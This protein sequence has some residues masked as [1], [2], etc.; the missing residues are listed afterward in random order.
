LNNKNN[1]PDM[2]T[3]FFDG[4]KT[5]DGSDIG[6][7]LIDPNQGKTLISCRLEFE[8]TKNTVEYKSLVQGLNKAIDLEVK[9]MKV[10]GDSKII[11]RQVR[12]TIHFLSLHLKSYQQEVW[13]L[14]YSFDAFNINS[15]P[16]DQ[17]V[18]IDI[19]ANATSRFM[20][21]DDGFSI[22]LIVITEKS[23][24]TLHIMVEERHQC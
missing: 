19:L 4:S 3:M 11:D 8:C 23:S 9:H 21:P 7:V 6:C 5:H 15:I 16:H 22:E 17:N 14:I 2:W 24:A 1:I 18:D 13:N 12:N 20:P 10:F